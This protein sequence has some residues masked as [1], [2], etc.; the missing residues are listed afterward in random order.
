MKQKTVSK[1]VKRGDHANLTVRINGRTRMVLENAVIG[2]KP[3]YSKKERAYLL[4][5]WME[6]GS[7]KVKVNQITEL[8]KR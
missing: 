7:F 8:F 5:I 6:G 3:R 4:P 1:M 2:G